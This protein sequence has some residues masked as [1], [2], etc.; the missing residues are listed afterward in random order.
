MDD[1]GIKKINLETQQYHNG[2]VFPLVYDAKD[3]SDAEA[4]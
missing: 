3:L 2:S 1:I 4:C